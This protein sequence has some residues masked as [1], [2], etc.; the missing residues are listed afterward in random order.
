MA[1]G[2]GAVSQGNPREGRGEGDCRSG[3]EELGP[4]GGVRAKMDVA[5][6]IARMGTDV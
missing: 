2:E 3:G 4:L 5:P 1:H 6:R